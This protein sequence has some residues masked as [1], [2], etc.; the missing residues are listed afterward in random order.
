MLSW[1]LIAHQVIRWEPLGDLWGGL[2]VASE[3]ENGQK[4]IQIRY[5]FVHIPWQSPCFP[6]VKSSPTKIFYLD[7]SWLTRSLMEAFGNPRGPFE[8][9]GDWRPSKNASN[10]WIFLCPPSMQATPSFPIVKPSHSRLFY[11]DFS[12]H[13]RLSHWEPLGILGGPLGV[14]FSS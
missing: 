10:H 9:L 1:L 14:P 13:S 8:A 6:T 4:R 2:G 3:P 12:W 5:F 11:F 7:F